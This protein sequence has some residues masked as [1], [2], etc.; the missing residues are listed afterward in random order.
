MQM[1]AWI[2]N[3]AAYNNGQLIGEWCTIS[4]DA[5][6]NAAHIAR[7][8]GD[9][10][11]Y[12]GDFDSFPRALCAKIGE[13][14]GAAD[15]AACVTLM[16]AVRDA[17]PDAVDVDDMLDCYL[18]AYGYGK[19]LSDLAD[20]AEEWISD[21]FAGTYDTLTHFAESFMEDTGGLEGM[22]EH[23][24]NYFDFEAYGRDMELGGDVNTSRV[25][26]GL[27]VFWNR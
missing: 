3:L 24:R 27:L 8:C 1:Q 23:L 12:V 18:D 21:H 4:D 7:I 25:S 10:E 15:L 14:V 13:Y 6:D 2:G 26:G 5:D 17:T 16:R 9:V 20:D 19:S 11:H 22:P